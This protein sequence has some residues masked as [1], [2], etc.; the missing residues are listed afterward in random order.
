M[1]SQSLLMSLSFLLVVLAHSTASGEDGFISQEAMEKMHADVIDDVVTSQPEDLIEVIVKVDDESD[2]RMLAE[3]E[4]IGDVQAEIN[5]TSSVVVEVPAERVGEIAEKDFVDNIYPIYTFTTNLQQSVP[6][7]NA[8]RVRNDMFSGVNLTGKGTTVCI[9]DT[10]VDYTHADL[11]GCPSTS[12]INTAG[13]SRVIGGRDFVNG[14]DNPMDDNGHGTHVAGIVAAN[15]GIVGVAPNV[16]I[17]AIKALDSGGSGTGSDI[18]SGIDWCVNNRTALNITVISMSLGTTTVFGSYCDASDPAMAAAIDSAVANNITVVVSS[19]NSGSTSG[20]SDPACVRNSTAIGSSTDGDA[21]SSFTNRNSLLDLLAPGSV[22][23]STQNGGGY[24]EQSGTSMAAPHA[25]AA[26]AIMYQKHRLIYGTFPNVSHIEGLVKGSGVRIADGGTGLSFTRL[27]LRN[28]SNQIGPRVVLLVSNSSQLTVERGSNITLASLW[29]DNV[30][31]NMAVLST[32]ETGSF[33]NHTAD[34]SSPFVFSNNYAWSNFSWSNSSLSSGTVVQW[35]VFTNDTYGNQNSTQ[36]INFTVMDT[37]LTLSNLSQSN[38]SA[39][40]RS[41]VY[42]FNVTATDFTG[43]ANATFEWNS[44]QN[45]T[46]Y[47]FNTINSTSRTYYANK[48]DLS[49]GSYTYRWVVNDTLGNFNV[50]SGSLV[51]NKSAPSMSL[52]VSPGNSTVFGS[53]VSVNGTVSNNDTSFVLNLTRNGVVVNSTANVTAISGLVIGADTHNFTL[54]Y[55]GTQN[56]SSYSISN[57]TIVSPAPTNT[58]LFLNGTRGNFTVDRGEHVNITAN[59][60]VSGSGLIVAILTN[61]TGSISELNSSTDSARLNSSTSNLSA[62]AYNV[63]ASYNGSNS[64]YSASGEWFLIF[65]REAVRTQV[66]I[67]NGTLQ[68]LSGSGTNISLDFLTNDTIINN[69]TN[70]T[71]GVDNPVGAQPSGI[72]L[73]FIRINVT[74]QIANNLTFSVIR[75]TYLESEIPSGVDEGS[76]RISRFNGTAWNKFDGSLVGGVDTNT[77][78]IFANTTRFSDFAV[79]GEVATVPVV[80]SSSSSGGGGGGGGGSVRRV[81]ATQTQPTPVVKENVTIPNETVQVAPT[82]ETDGPTVSVE[83]TNQ[84]SRGIG[85]VS[86]SPT[87][88]LAIAAAVAVALTLI[89][90]FRNRLSKSGIKPSWRP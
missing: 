35:R 87:T 5:I 8:S 16:S 20:I 3:L 26:F 85:R 43:V 45:T 23:N 67:T 37:T 28:A 10:G 55:N 44:S 82:N 73:K 1:F 64:N 74:S 29:S 51:V 78:V 71:I 39:Y 58:S 30:D 65:V 89:F 4:K 70:I 15:G 24:V 19:G 75:Y 53:V 25:S 83:V 40:Q 27:N 49:A 66:N 48:T 81:N 38:D 79:S 17:V 54:I 14:D 60:S 42:S 76:L 57:V 46:V 31:L 80:S 9:I 86:V 77:N 52:I 7:T 11:G 62:T 12:N 56:F 47:L 13:C 61:Y 33:V 36:S 32:N 69:G 59:V 21:V 72:P 63:T 34:Y 68:T 88:V 90:L 6:I 41:A 22:I 50:L 2:R 18:I 84:T